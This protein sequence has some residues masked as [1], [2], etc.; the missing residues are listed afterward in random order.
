MGADNLRI[1]I[2]DDNP[3]IHQ[4][5]FKIFSQKD[6]RSQDTKAEL[7]KIEL[8]LFGQTTKESFFP[9]FEID[10][11]SQGEEGVIKVE[12]SL[13]TDKPF[14]LAFVDI[15]MPPGMDG[16]ETIKLIWELDSTIQIVICS[17][18]TDS[19]WEQAIEKLGK[20]DNLVI[21]RKPFDNITVRQLAFA[22]TKKWYLSLQ[23]LQY[24]SS[25]EERVS[26]RTQ[27]LQNSFSL[28]R[29]TLDSSPEG[30]IV[31]DTNQK[32]I[33][34]NN[35]FLEIWNLSKIVLLNF[36]DSETIMHFISNQ[37]AENLEYLSQFKKTLLNSQEVLQGSIRVKD[38]HYEYYTKPY[39]SNKQIIGRL[40]SFRDVSIRASLE[41]KLHFQATHDMLTKLPNRVLLTEFMNQAMLNA[42]RNKTLLAIFFLDLDGFKLINDSLNHNIGDEVLCGVA[43]R[44]QQFIRK[45]DIFARLGGDEF[46]IVSGDLKQPTDI[47]NLAKNI[48]MAFTKPFL[49]SGHELFLT[50]SIG[51]CFYPMDGNTID[52]LLRNADSAMYQAKDLGA[53]QFQFY[54]E[55]LNKLN[56]LRLE[57]ETELRRGLLNEEFF[58]CYQPQYNLSTGTLVS[59][60]ALIRWNHPQRGLLKP[61]DFIPFAED[62]GLIVSIDEWVLRTVCKQIKSWQDLG[63]PLIR[64][65][66]NVTTKQFK[67]YNFPKVVETVIESTGIPPQYLE[68]ELSESIMINNPEI[69]KSIARLKD[70]GVKIALDDFGT[71]YS[72]LSYLRLIPLDRLKI[73]RSF[74]QRI[75]LNAEDD[76]IIKAIIAIAKG[77]NLEIL[78]EGVE[79]QMQLDFL[80]NV[81]CGEIQGFLFNEPLKLDECTLLLKNLL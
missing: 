51:I 53:N 45:N 58:L 7:S 38:K 56:L 52:I 9:D 41:Q 72:A 39:T 33:D 20:T 63:L 48:I 8:E 13:K 47:I 28:V 60:E 1:L 19:S 79:T 43:N 59:M 36:K 34:F 26:T 76:V 57:K 74:I 10:T 18:C 40:W 32:I 24:K 12:K 23:A 3:T 4:D 73:D 69:I 46:V 61:I 81:Q 29:A 6:T 64:I 16:V 54:T 78:A 5:F 11:A 2:I 50:T 77:L 35:K 71:G 49:V 67:A 55:N 44:L 70:I 21:L 22:L 68:F 62:T 17:A 65:A 75:G 31:V 37:M 80:K 25:L 66:V 15:H 14:A 30:I 42:D 27:S